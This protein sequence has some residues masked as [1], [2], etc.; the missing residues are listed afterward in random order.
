MTLYINL[1]PTLMYRLF[2]IP[3]FRVAKVLTS[4]PF[5]QTFRNLFLKVFFRCFHPKTLKIPIISS[6]PNLSIE[7]GA[8]V[9]A[10]FIL[11]I[12]P[13]NFFK[14]IF[15]CLNFIRSHHPLFFDNTLRNSTFLPNIN[16]ACWKRLD[17]IVNNYFSFPG[18]R[19]IFSRNQQV[20]FPLLL[21]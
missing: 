4:K 20:E 13:L 2:T 16:K 10:N 17:L 9:R 5:H 19:I 7:A 8:K 21:P 15:F 14:E 12:P 11:P 3:S 6:P 18:K 1:F